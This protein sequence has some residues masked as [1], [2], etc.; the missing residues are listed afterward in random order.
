[1]AMTTQT[2]PRSKASHG[3]RRIGANG[4]AVDPCSADD[5]FTARETPTRD[6]APAKPVPRPRTHPRSA[7]PKLRARDVPTVVAVIAMVGAIAWLSWQMALRTPS[8]LAGLGAIFGAA[9]LGVTAAFAGVRT[10]R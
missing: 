10:P 1:M 9:A 2:K 5:R 8:G 7:S 6:A 4:R 3:R